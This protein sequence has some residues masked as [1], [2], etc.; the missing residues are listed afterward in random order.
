MAEFRSNNLRI[1]I[2]EKEKNYSAF[3]DAV[4]RAVISQKYICSGNICQEHYQPRERLLNSLSVVFLLFGKSRQQR[5]CGSVEQETLIGFS[6]CYEELNDKI[7][8]VDNSKVLYIDVIG[9]RSAHKQKL[10]SSSLTVSE[11]QLKGL[12]FFL[13]QQITVYAFQKKFLGLRLSSLGYVL[14]Y[15][16]RFGF[17]HILSI[18]EKEDEK[19]SECA[20]KCLTIPYYL[21]SIEFDQ[22]FY[23]H[24][25]LLNYIH[26]LIKNGFSPICEKKQQKQTKRQIIQFFDNQQ[27]SEY[28]YEDNKYKKE[29]KKICDLSEEGFTMMFNFQ[30]KENREKIKIWISENNSK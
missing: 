6:L 17:R 9:A 21:D 10:N 14:G 19:I 22:N 29:Y 13:L 11:K 27:S 5:R 30:T 3:S 2:H 1:E 18:N 24:P 4:R 15:Y 12:G 7:N 25:E 26:L 16:R 8:P 28:L 23:K 20:E